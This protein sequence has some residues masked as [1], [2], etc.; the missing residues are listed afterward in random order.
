MGLDEDQSDIYS[1]VDEN[2]I[3]ELV[4]SF[5]HES[6]KISHAKV[7]PLNSED[8]TECLAYLVISLEI[9]DNCEISFLEHQKLSI[10][11]NA[12]FINCLFK[13]NDIYI[14][15]QN[16]RML[17]VKENEVY[18]HDTHGAISGVACYQ[19]QMTGTYYE[20]N[21]ELDEFHNTPL[22]SFDLWNQPLDPYFRDQ[23]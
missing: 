12:Q 2:S 3:I 10:A 6:I 1:L 14:L 19:D 17:L 9:P 11:L 13:L 7:V 20:L 5:L 15:D 16:N 8:V 21:D 4:K 22:D 23:S 18:W